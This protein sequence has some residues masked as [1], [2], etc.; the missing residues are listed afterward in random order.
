MVA[1]DEESADRSIDPVDSEEHR[2]KKKKKKK[3]HDKLVKYSWVILYLSVT[4][5]PGKR[6]S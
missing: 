6:K 2:A 4:I 1:A 3:K 5:W